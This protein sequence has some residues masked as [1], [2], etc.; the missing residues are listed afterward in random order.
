LGMALHSPSTC[1]QLSSRMTRDTDEGVYT[2]N[3]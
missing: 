1:R 2:L 3:G